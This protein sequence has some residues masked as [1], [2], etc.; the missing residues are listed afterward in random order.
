MAALFCLAGSLRWC[1][2]DR[3]AS[4]ICRPL[5]TDIGCGCLEFWS[6]GFA[7]VIV[8]LDCEMSGFGVSDAGWMEVVSV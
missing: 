1:V 5:V 6:H 4:Q 8:V 3:V 7:G 2:G